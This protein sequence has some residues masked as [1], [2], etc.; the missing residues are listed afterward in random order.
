MQQLFDGYTALPFQPVLSATWSLPL[1]SPFNDTGTTGIRIVAKGH[2]RSISGSLTLME[3]C[4]F[5]QLVAFSR[6]NILKNHQEKIHQQQGLKRAPRFQCT[7]TGC[8]SSFYVFL[9]K[10]APTLSYNDQLGMSNS[11]CCI[12]LMHV[13]T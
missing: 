13:W 6:S 10:P 8:P 11:R 12:L 2:R 1:G 9:E 5:A 4:T 7:F 3:R